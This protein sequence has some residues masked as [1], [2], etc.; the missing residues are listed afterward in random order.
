MDESRRVAFRF[1]KF[2]LDDHERVLLHDGHTVTLTQKAFDLL[3][4]LVRNGGHLVTKDELLNEVWPDAVVAEVNLSVNISV[5][6][7]AL[8]DDGF[9]ETVPKRGYR[10]VG[11]VEV[12][13]SEKLEQRRSASI[14]AVDGTEQDSLSGPLV[15]TIAR[16]RL[17]I[18]PLVLILVVGMA[19]FWF[20]KSSRATTPI[21]SIA[22]L[23]FV[24]NDATNDYLADGL[25]EATINSLSRVAKLRVAPRTNVLRYKAPSINL[26]QAGEELGV[27]AI[28]TGQ[29]SQKDDVLS[30][31]LDLVDVRRNSEIFTSQYTGKASELISLQTR[32]FDDVS[33]ALNV[34]LTGPERQLLAHR[35]TEN[36]D[37]YRAYLEGRY[38]WN[39]R[40][41][42][43]LKKAIEAF[44][45][46]T[47]IDSNFALAYSGLADSYTTLGYLSYISPT[48]A[49][50]VAKN[51]ALRAIELDSTLAEPH[52][53][54]AYDKFY[55][56]WDWTGAESEFRRAIELNPTYATA[57][58]WYS[59]YLL[60]AGRPNE[61]FQEIYK[62][63][64]YDPLSLSINTD[65]GFHHYYNKQYEEAIKQLMSVLEMK[66]DFPLA[67]LWL[68]RSYQ[69]L[70]RY[71]EALAEFR[72]VEGAFGGWAVSKAALGYV[73][74]VSGNQREASKTLSELEA[75]SK[76][77]FITAYGVALVY[78]GKGEKDKAFAWLNKA[79]DERSHWLIWLR[80][81]PRWDVLR[82]DP[83][84]G[85]LLNRMHFP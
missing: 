33:H 17:V 20:T 10:F 40:S 63:R 27:S 21:D 50:P 31:Q 6:R 74:G 58:Q 22:V 7:K 34:P 5:L 80:L 67:H 3:V 43:G 28:L 60:A 26:R 1:G 61:A 18:V 77:R 54:L 30:I 35:A 83:R 32:I 42:S 41:E 76:Q 48:Q 11:P 82:S 37:A 12:V 84:F 59:V 16:H 66:K 24:S 65:V 55:F 46:A 81:D 44:E 78:A 14:S 62:A 13:D 70:G 23:P 53:S 4:V 79:F 29:V 19:V 73:E 45:R 25:S 69:Q 15:G 36:A 71:Q 2:L 8:G 52:V 72:Q 39:Q 75:L 51:H 57:H 64:Q 38:F 68:G 49:F 47:Q 85:E 56:D 9:I